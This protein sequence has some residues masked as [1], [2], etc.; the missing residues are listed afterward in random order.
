MT[1]ERKAPPH[2]WKPGQSGNPGGKPK[3]ATNHATRLITALMEDGAKEIAQSVV[4]QAKGGNL[5][6]ARLVLERLAPPVR[7]RAIEI[8]LPNTET[9]AGVSK[10]QQLVLEAV[11]GGELL[12]GEGQIL[13]GIIETRRKAI[14]TEELERRIA[15]LE[16][17][18]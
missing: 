14:E 4:D 16:A 8:E 12:P 13:T 18:K 10:A 15:A 7:E 6:A 2:A 5:M 9:A 1:T 3:G 11:G 17:K